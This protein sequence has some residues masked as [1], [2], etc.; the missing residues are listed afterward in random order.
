MLFRER[1]LTFEHHVHVRYMLLSVYL[2]SACL[3]VVFNVHA[4]WSAD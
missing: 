1:E 4:L 3:S 2:S